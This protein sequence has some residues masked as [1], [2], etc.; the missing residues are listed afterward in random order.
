MNKHFQK[1]VENYKFKV[2]KLINSNYYAFFNI[3]IIIFSAIALSDG[4]QKK[5]RNILNFIFFN[6]DKVYS[7]FF[8][9]DFLLNFS[10]KSIKEIFTTFWG[11]FDVCVLIISIASL[12]GLWNFTSLRLWLII[13]YLDKVPGLEFTSS[14]CSAL[15]K[16]MSIIKDIGIFALF[17]FTCTGIFSVSFWSGKMTTRCVDNAGNIHSEDRLCSTNSK[18]GHHCPTNYTCKAIDDS[19]DSGTISFDNIFIAWLNI[20]QIL[21]TEGWSTIYFKVADIS[22]KLSILFFIIIIICGNWLLLQL[23]VATVVQSLKSQVNIKRKYNITKSKTFMLDDNSNINSLKRRMTNFINNNWIERGILLITIIDT[24]FIAMVNSNISGSLSSFIVYLEIVCTTIFLIEMLIKIYVLGIYGYWKSSIYNVMDGIFTILSIFEIVFSSDSGVAVFRILR[25][26]RIL[27]LTKF[28]PQLS[29]LISVFCDSA[30]PLCSLFII[31]IL[32]IIIFSLFTIQFFEGGMN[33][34]ENRPKNNLENFYY[35]FLSVV[36]LYT[37][38]N[39]DSIKDTVNESKGRYATLI[40][41]IIIIVGAYIF[42]QFLVAILLNAFIDRLQADDFYKKI[43]DRK[44]NTKHIIKYVIGELFE[45]RSKKDKNKKNNKNKNNNSNNSTE[46][47]TEVEN[48]TEQITEKMEQN[49]EE[50]KLENDLYHHDYS[51]VLK[52]E[53]IMPKSFLLPHEL[54]NQNDLEQLTTHQETNFEILSRISSQS[55]NKRKNDLNKLEPMFDICDLQNENDNKKEIQPL[56]FDT[57]NFLC[58]SVEPTFTNPSDP[59]KKKYTIEIS[60]AKNIARLTGAG[61]TNVPHVFSQVIKDN[62]KAS[63]ERKKI[64]MEENKEMKSLTPPTSPKIFK[65]LLHNKSRTNKTNKNIINDSNKEIHKEN[66]DDYFTIKMESSDHPKSSIDITE[67]NFDKQND[68]LKVYSPTNKQDDNKL[69]KKMKHVTIKTSNNYISKLRKIHKKYRDSY[70]VH[71]CYKTIKNDVYFYFISLV[72]IASCISLALETPD[73][74]DSKHYYILNKC[75]IFYTIVFIFDLIFN[76]IAYGALFTRR[77]YLKRLY[78]WID[79]VVVFISLLN[80]LNYGN[81][82]HSLRIFRLV[83]ILKFFKIH[84]GLR[85]VSISV[86]KT[87]PS[88]F[89]ALIPYAFYI[90]ICSSVSLSLFANRGWQCNDDTVIVKSQCTGNYTNEYGITEKRVWLPYAVTYDNFFDSILSSFIIS[91]QEAW[92]DIMY[93]YIE[94]SYSSDTTGSDYHL[95]YSI[96]FVLSVLVGNWLFLSVV[97]ALIFNNLKRHQDILRGIQYLSDGQ[98]KLLDYIKLIITNKP[99]FPIEKSKSSF[100][101]KIR[102]FIQTKLFNRISFSVIGINVIV[103]MLECTKNNSTLNKFINYSEVVFIII[104]TLEVILLLYGYGIKYFFKDYWNILSFA[105]VVSSLFSLFNNSSM[106]PIIFSSIRLLRVLRIIKYAKGLKALGIA[107]FFNFT[108]L[109]NVLFLMFIVCFIFAVIGYHYFGNINVKYA[110]YLNEQLNFSSFNNSLI[111][112]FI[113]CTG[114]GWPFALADCTGKSIHYTCDSSKE[115]CGSNWAIVYFIALQVIFNWILL[116]SFIAITVDTFVTVLEEHDEIVRLEK[117][118]NAFNQQWIKYDWNKSGDLTFVEL[119]NMYNSFKLPKG[120]E[121]GNQNRENGMLLVKPPMEEIFKNVKVYKNRCKYHDVIFGFLNSWM[122]EELPESFLIR[123]KEKV[124]TGYEKK[125]FEKRKNSIYSL[126]NSIS[127]EKKKS[128]RNKIW[129]KSKNKYNKIVEALSLRSSKKGLKDVNIHILVEHIDQDEQIVDDDNDDDTLNSDTPITLVEDYIRMNMHTCSGRLQNVYT[130]SLMETV[131]ANNKHKNGNVNTPT[132]ATPT[133]A[134]PTSTTIFNL[135]DSNKNDFS[136]DTLN[137]LNNSRE[138]KNKDKIKDK[139]KQKEK[140]LKNK[141]RR[142]DSLHPFMKHN[143]NSLPY[144]VSDSLKNQEVSNQ[145]SEDNKIKNK[146]IIHRNLVRNSTNHTLGNQN[147]NLLH[148][149]DSTESLVRSNQEEDDKYKNKVSLRRDNSHRHLKRNSTNQTLANQNQNYLRTDNII[150]NDP[151]FY[152]QEEDKYKNKVLHCENSKYKLKRNSTNLTI[153][154]QNFL[155][156]DS[157]VNNESFLYRPQLLNPISTKNNNFGI[158][159]NNEMTLEPQSYESNSESQYPLS[160]SRKDSRSTFLEEQNKV[161]SAHK[162]IEHLQPVKEVSYSLENKEDNNCRVNSEIKEKACT[163]STNKE[164]NNYT[165][166]FTKT[167]RCIKNSKKPERLTLSNIGRSK[168]YDNNFD[169]Y[170]TP[171]DDDIHRSIIELDAIIGVDDEEE[172]KKNKHRSI[173]I[174]NNLHR[175]KS[176]TSFRMGFKDN[177]LDNDIVIDVNSQGLPFHVVYAVYQIQ[178][179]FKKSRKEHQRKNINSNAKEIHKD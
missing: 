162:L 149:A 142:E 160:N 170:H 67:M 35:S 116:N 94:S 138:E 155:S 12:F 100:R 118:W 106:S 61:K 17:F 76:I 145:K 33:I 122:G 87:I 15:S 130:D 38:E 32:S 11:L 25:A 3:I 150:T 157:I 88:L 140:L 103:M 4:N 79:V 120:T 143:S 9:F 176:R 128:K 23:I 131:R 10:V 31:W 29:D 51:S 1:F 153:Q 42:S 104:Y 5:D 81:K 92:P 139:E 18:F 158:S 144:N 52:Q 98:R 24:V 154:N 14:I 90:L 44:S 163:P 121:W 86:W 59:P 70:F 156:T 20:F 102:Y 37:V 53:D 179:R 177:Y 161:L 178:Q 166:N 49:Q 27:R 109:F 2:K 101:N 89:V 119:V 16:S 123:E 173:H 105:I 34:I 41:V 62:K 107:I 136:S 82:F 75:D 99:N 137:E 60:D 69:K 133:T 127:S 175:I 74:H 57:P 48:S 85:I 95:S 58:D 172:E 141:I 47:S 134:T 80:I 21:T 22:S 129:E 167:K 63:E 8:I 40:P 91:H 55:R 124:K 77:A 113:F 112:V 117:M 6:L 171:K 13:K 96:Y 114:E 115:N 164:E 71:V 174:K 72:T 39:W 159:L 73:P 110:S 46:E 108:Q 126:E 66:L 111:S 169:I 78:N 28:L 125:V 50:V 45:Q 146:S 83:R 148:N 36:Q 30:K 54:N 135:F 56:E 84:D 64:L 152:R 43:S 68:I 93:H 26:F 97:T 165:V 132:T 151:L 7:I 65:K 19:M 147:N 168:S